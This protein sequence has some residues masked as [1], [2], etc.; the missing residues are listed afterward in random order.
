MCY[1][2]AMT[3]EQ[4]KIL[5]DSVKSISDSLWWFT[6][7]IKVSVFLTVLAFVGAFLFLLIGY[8]DFHFVD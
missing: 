3:V 2:I 8:A 5:V 6:F 4:E 7:G 1:N